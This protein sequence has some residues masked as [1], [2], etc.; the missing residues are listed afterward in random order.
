LA[1]NS[2]RSVSVTVTSS[3]PSTTWALVST[4]AVVGNDEAGTDAAL[5]LLLVR[6]AAAARRA[7]RAA[8]IWPPKKRRRNSCISSSPWPSPRRTFSVVRILTTA[9]PTLSTMSAKSGRPAMAAAWTGVAGAAPAEEDIRFA[10]VSIRADRIALP[11]LLVII[12]TVKRAM[13]D[14]MV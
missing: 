9:G 7:V 3:A 13:D 11:V 12:V 2:R 4:I 8:F 6:A 10:P 5:H 14:R 1:L